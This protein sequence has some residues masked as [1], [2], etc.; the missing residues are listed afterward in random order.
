MAETEPLLPSRDHRVL[1]TLWCLLTESRVFVGITRGPSREHPAGV[2]FVSP[3][4][5]GR[6]PGQPR[7]SGIAVACGGGLVPH[8]VGHPGRG[9]LRVADTCIVTDFCNDCRGFPR[10]SPRRWPSCRPIVPSPQ[11]PLRPMAASSRARR[12][13]SPQRPTERAASW[14]SEAERKLL[15]S[16][17]GHPLAEATLRQLTV[18]IGRVRRLRDTWRKR[19]DER[20]R[21]AR[22]KTLTGTPVDSQALDKAELFAAALRRL[23]ARLAEL[24]ADPSGPRAAGRAPPRR[25]SP[26]AAAGA[27]ATR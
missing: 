26:R 7:R 16:S 24:A 4:R 1:Q 19:F 12:P 14:L 20:L 11:D 10:P 17:V 13:P 2:G 21:A 15:E 3:R 22:R 18:T 23:E 27:R 5:D 6:Q 8:A 9:P 25:L